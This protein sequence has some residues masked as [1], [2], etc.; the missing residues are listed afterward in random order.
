MGAPGL[1]SSLGDNTGEIMERDIGP[2]GTKI[3][4]NKREGSGA[5]EM[6]KE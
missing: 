6:R 5:E 2:E 1:E 4:T 3:K